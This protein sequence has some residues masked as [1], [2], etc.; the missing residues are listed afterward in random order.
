M[1]TKSSGDIDLSCNCL[2]AIWKEAIL[3][4]AICFGFTAIR[5]KNPSTRLMAENNT[6]EGNSY[7]ILRHRK[8]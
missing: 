4:Q 6:S 3:M 2:I 8:M 1:V 5:S 7:Q